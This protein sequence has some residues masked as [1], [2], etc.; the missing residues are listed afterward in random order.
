M[1]FFGTQCNQHTGGGGGCCAKDVTN[2][3][4]GFGLLTFKPNGG[5][6]VELIRLGKNCTLQPQSRGGL[7]V[8][9]EF[10]VD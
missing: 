2:S 7:Y 9:S 6:N 10:G 1:H 4:A 8:H 5:M 3:Q